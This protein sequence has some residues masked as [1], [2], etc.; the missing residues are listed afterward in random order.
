MN[1]I[2]KLFGLPYKVYTILRERFFLIPPPG[3]HPP[4]PSSIMGEGMGGDEFQ[5]SPFSTYEVGKVME[6]ERT[7]TVHP[8]PLTPPTRGGGKTFP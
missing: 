5:P 3:T 8:P 1:I 7:V 2:K 4:Q 6:E